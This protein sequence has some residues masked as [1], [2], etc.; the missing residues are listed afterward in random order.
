MSYNCCSGNFSSQSLRCYRSASRSSSG[1]S[2]PSNLV[3]ST[4]SCRPTACQLGSSVYRSCQETR[5]D[6]TSCQKSCV[7]SRPCQTNCSSPRSS[8]PCSPCQP[9][10]A[11]SLDFGSNSCGSGGYRSRSCF[12]GDCGSSGFRSLNYGVHSFPARY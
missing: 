3:Y 11:G 4:N 9:T 1:S 7:V 5:D 10:Y 6:S 12:S 2:Y 8:T